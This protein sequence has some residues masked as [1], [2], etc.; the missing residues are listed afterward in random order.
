MSTPATDQA[1]DQRAETRSRRHFVLRRLHSLSGVV[2][3]GVFLMVHLWT[4]ARAVYGRDAFGHAVGEIQSTPMLAWV[5]LFAIFLPLAF[6]AVYGVVI[7]AQGSANVGRYAFTRNWMY[8]LQ[9]VSGVVVLA[10]V[11]GHLWEFRVQKWLFGMSASAFYPQLEAHLAWTAFGVPWIALGYL[12]GLAA[13]VFH[14]ANG[15]V[16]FCMSWGITV[17]RAAQ[18]RAAWLFGLGGLALFGLA[19]A[20]VLRLATGTILLPGLDREPTPACGTTSPTP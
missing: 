8:V 20:T 6:H 14:L 3:V 10:F 19:V 4:N 15:L 16:T 18:R 13:S 12:L 5:E 2:P 7:A 11:L 9:R 17:G 1:P